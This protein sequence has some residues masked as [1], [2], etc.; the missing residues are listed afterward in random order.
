MVNT[1]TTI[2]EN[3]TRKSNFELLRIIT[4]LFIV[5]HHFVVHGL[6]I[7]GYSRLYPEEHPTNV[8][9]L[10]NSFFVIGV[11]VFV[12]I[13]G[14][15]SIKQ[16][17]KSFLRLYAICLFYN[18]LLAVLIENYSL[19]AALKDSI[20][21]FS[22]NKYWFITDYFLLWLI[23]PVLNSVIEGMKGNKQK[24]ILFLILFAVFEFYFGWFWKGAYSFNGYNL[25][26]FM[27]LYFIGRFISLH[28]KENHS[29]RKWYLF[30]YLFISLVTAFLMIQTQFDDIR[31]KD[32]LYDYNSPLIIIASVAFLLLFRNINIKSKA[33]NW[34]A[35]SVLAI[36]LITES[37]WVGPK[38]LYPFIYNYMEKT[39]ENGWLLTLYIFLLAIAIVIACLLI[40]RIRILISKPIENLLCKIPVERYI[41]RAIYELDKLIQ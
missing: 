8:G 22:D 21:I 2:V 24:F 9:F 14:Y 12:L 11:N 38:Y 1:K 17:W 23:S 28:T 30:T 35:S 34:L 20:R 5:L 16:S 18:V 15:F 41:K 25:W 27:F 19:F 13:S 6:R 26:N 3:I 29:L 36:Y 33:I 40:D 31:L 32:R 37:P 39:V 4:M 10:L 7:A